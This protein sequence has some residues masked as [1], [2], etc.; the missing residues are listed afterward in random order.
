MLQDSRNKKIV[1]KFTDELNGNLMTEFI[2]L[3]SKM[4]A[5]KI[6]EKEKKICKGISRA[7][8]ERDLKFQDYYNCLFNNESRSLVNRRFVSIN[9]QVFTQEVTKRGLSAS[10]DKRYYIN[11]VQSVPYS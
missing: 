10:D 6:A 4:Y 5:Y 1:G 9:H 2:S 11:N 3:R 7:V 8:I